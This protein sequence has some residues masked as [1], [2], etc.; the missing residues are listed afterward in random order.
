MRF[1]E[2]LNDP[3][4]VWKFNPNDLKE[5]AMWDDYM[6]AYEKAMEETS[7]EAAPWYVIPADSKTNRNLLIS[8]IL[9]QT[10]QGLDLQYPPKPAEFDN[11]TIE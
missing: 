8:E 6:R 9:L 3:T 7:T 10:L 4:K 11:I 5:R 2:R 1:E